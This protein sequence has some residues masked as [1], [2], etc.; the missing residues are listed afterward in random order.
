MTK[1]AGFWIVLSAL[2]ANYFFGFELNFYRF[3][4]FDTTLH[5]LGGL[6]VYFLISQY[7]RND[8]AN[9]SWLNRTILLAWTTALVGIIWEFA[10]Y[11]ATIL[12]VVLPNSTGGFNFIGD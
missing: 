10:E 4:W 11:N 8:L 5:F 2:L 1:N 9:L 7:F 3:P 12:S 6:G